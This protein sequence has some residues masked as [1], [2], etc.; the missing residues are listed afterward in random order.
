MIKSRVG[1]WVMK[2][3]FK[4]KEVQTRK[5]RDDSKA[6]EWKLVQSLIWGD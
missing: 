6:R 1:D 3:M 5:R 2:E 4:S